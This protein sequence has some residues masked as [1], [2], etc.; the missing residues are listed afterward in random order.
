MNGIEPSNNLIQNR[1]KPAGEEALHGQTE[2]NN[3]Q[4]QAE[5][6]E[7]VPSVQVS[8]KARQLNS[9]IEAASKSAGSQSVV[10]M[11]RVNAVRDKLQNGQID[12]LQD[13][14]TRLASAEK[15]ADKLLE[16]DT[17]LPVEKI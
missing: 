16:I 11:A 9:A 3:T 8:E 13:M 12:I 7:P 15:I 2:R 4:A 14:E 6:G 5:S 10:D 17:N 1:A